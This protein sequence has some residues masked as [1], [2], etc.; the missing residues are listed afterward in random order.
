VKFYALN[1]SN[2]SGLLK[3]TCVLMDVISDIILL[4]IQLENVNL[5]NLL[6]SGVIV[7]ISVSDV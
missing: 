5:V 4:N 7:K 6:V 3:I 2:H 1:V